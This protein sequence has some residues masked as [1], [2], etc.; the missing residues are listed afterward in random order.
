MLSSVSLDIFPVFFQ[1][2]IQNYG[3]NIVCFITTNIHRFKWNSIDINVKNQIFNTGCITCITDLIFPRTWIRPYMMFDVLL[4][5]WLC[6]LRKIH[7]TASTLL[8]LLAD[9][10][11]WTI[12][13]FS[14]KIIWNVKCFSNKCHNVNRSIKVI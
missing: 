9:Y 12:F 3:Y 5:C 7:W 14:F 10:I 4:K 1:S 6:K 8:L 13:C 11:L 2:V